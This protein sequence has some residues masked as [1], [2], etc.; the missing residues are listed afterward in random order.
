APRAAA[1]HPARRRRRRTSTA[2]LAR[3]RSSESGARRR[4]LPARPPPRA[5][6]RRTRT[7]RPCT[8]RTWNGRRAD[9]RSSGTD[10]LPR[11]CRTRG[12]SR[13]WPTVWSR[14]LDTESYG[15]STV[16]EMMCAWHRGGRVVAF[17]H[18]AG[19]RG[20]TLEGGDEDVA[21]LADV[22][23]AAAR[24]QERLAAHD[25]PVALVDVWRDDQVHLPEVVLEQHEDDA[26]RRRGTLSRDREARVGNVAPVGSDEQ[27]AAG[28]RSR[29]KVRP[30]D[31]QGVDA[32]REGRLPVVGEP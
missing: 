2:T 31:R 27:L 30:Q 7:T 5:P 26:V 16:A 11:S 18:P 19:E 4:A 22:F 21:V 20:Q 6:R 23:E 12:T 32:D 1:C 17:G 15:G 9:R 14:S 3:R 25:C 10:R 29:R 24:E 8:R 28:Q 13:R